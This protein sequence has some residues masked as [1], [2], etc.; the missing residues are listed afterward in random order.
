MTDTDLLATPEVD[1]NPSSSGGRESES[2]QISKM[3][4]KTDVARSG[5]T[6]MLL[7]QLRALAG[8]LGIRGTSGMRKGD[9]IAAI[10][11]NQAG[12]PAKADKPARAEAKAEQAALDVTPAAEAKS[13]PA[14]ESKAKE[15]AP[16]EKAAAPAPETKA[17][18]EAEPAKSENAAPAETTEESGREG[19]QRGRGRQR[20]GRDQARS[21]GG[22]NA[23][24]RTEE[25]KSDAESG[26][27]RRNQ[28]ERNQ[29]ERNQGE[30]GERNQGDRN[31]NGEQQRNQG[32]RNQGDRN[33][34]GDDEESG[35]GRRGRRF[36]ERRRGRDREGGGGEARELEIRE[37]DVLQPVAGILD[38]LD[39]YAFVRT[40]GYLAGPNDVYVSMN[41]VRK[42]G[43]RRGDAITGAVRAPRDGEQSNQRQKFD[44]LVRLDTVNGGDV[45][46]AKRRPEF[47]KLTPLYPN[48]R[49]RLETQPNK[50]TTRVIDLI[51]PIG[52]GQ[53]ALIVSPP[54]AGKT[55]ILQDIANAIATNNPE[56]YLMVVLVDERPEEVTDMQRSVKGEVIASTFDRPPSDHTSVAELAIERAKRLVEMGKDVVVLLDS[57][58]RLGR[59][60]NN[61]SPASGRILSGGV[62]STALYP[63]KRFLGAARNIENGGSL[64]IIA[65]AMVETGSTGDTVIFEEFKGT[66][67]AELKLDRKIAERRVFPAVDVNP[68]GTRKDE[69]LLSPDE[70]AVL[71]KLRR[72]L[73]GL[74]SHQA[75]DLLIDRLKKSKNNLEF[76]M[77]VSKTAPGAL[78]E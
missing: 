17:P 8:E 34:G 58:T 66:G 23:D 10:K 3:S 73:S 32:E 41:L 43:L 72:V 11:E 21:G 59:A 27:R 52:K 37:D 15:A 46:A 19:G 71:H 22:D 26:E 38:V 64:T 53:R 14:E 65:T 29:G 76:L 60:Y 1:T 54:K 2:G 12:K 13:A 6:G 62:D 77:S 63:P 61:S 35:R 75:I 74:D 55:T 7:P 45:E 16:A 50:L 56:C 40:S 36:R 67:N 9:L 57:I 42:N 20:R 70:A 28:G 24:A 30:R 4:E 33:Q 5:L 44:P 78:D 49:L 25:Q 18:A 68:S 51:M 47:G 48:Q 31:R 69:L 39:N